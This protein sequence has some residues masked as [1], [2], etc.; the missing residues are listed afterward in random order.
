V[1]DQWTGFGTA[2]D[3]YDGVHPNAAGDQK[4]SDRWYPALTALLTGGPTVPPTPPVTPT[5]TPTPT[6]P[7]PAGGCTAVYKTTNQWSGGFQGEVTVS[8]AGAAPIT[9][10][11]TGWTFTGRQISQAWNATLTQTGAAVSARNAAW[12]GSLAPGAT[13]TFGFIASGTGS[14]APQVSCTIG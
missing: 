11:A 8:N 7:P 6:V 12:N 13:A 3:T 5:P 1:V 2:S 14:P 10:W 4:M 9:A